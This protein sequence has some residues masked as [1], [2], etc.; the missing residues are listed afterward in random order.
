MQPGACCR[1]R[2][3]LQLMLNAGDR[4]L[5]EY[6]SN[7]KVLTAEIKEEFKS[8]HFIYRTLEVKT[9]A[10]KRLHHSTEFILTGCDS[11]F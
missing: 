6:K 3:V 5:F 11:L 10:L 7:I 9:W 1:E 4:K 2:T 8:A